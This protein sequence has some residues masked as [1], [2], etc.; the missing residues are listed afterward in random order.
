[1]VW[2]KLQG[3]HRFPTMKSWVPNI[4]LNLVTCDTQALQ[5]HSLIIMYD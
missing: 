4:Q 3:L 1:M 2:E 5:E